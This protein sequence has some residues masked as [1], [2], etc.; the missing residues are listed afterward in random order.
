MFTQDKRLIEV[1][2]PLGA[3]ALV[4]HGLSGSEFISGLFRFS[5]DLL[6]EESARIDPQALLGQSVSVSMLDDNRKRYF[7]GIVSKVAT[8]RRDEHFIHYY[9]EVVPWFWRLSL[10]TTSRIFQD[11]TVVQIIESIFEELKKSFPEVNYRDATTE[12]HIA[13][14]Y[15]VQYRETDLSFVSRLME[16]EGIF[17]FFEHS[18]NKHTLIF[19]DSS[20]A[21]TSC[22]GKSQILYREGGTGEGEGIIT[23]W[24]E[25]WAELSGKYSMRDHH[26]Q[27]P[28]KSL[29]VNDQAHDTQMSSLE[30][31]DYPGE[32]VARF[33]KP[34]QRLA[35]VEKEGQKRIRIHM[36]QELLDE[37]LSAGRSSRR[38]L[39]AGYKFT[40]AKHFAC[41]GD[42]ILTEV[43]HSVAQS[44]DYIS[45]EVANTPYQNRFTCVP[46]KTHLR[47]R[48]VSHK[49]VVSGPQTAVVAVKSGEESWLDKFGRVRVQFFWEREGKDNETSACWVRVAQKWAGTGWGA[50]FWP[51]LGQEV[52]VEFLEGD[53]DRPLITG[54]VY[55]PENMPP[56]ALP[57]NYTRSG[58]VTETSKYNS[59]TNF[60]E[61]RFED[62]EDHEQ[63]FINAERDMDWRVEHDQRESTGNNR[64]LVVKTN[65]T[66]LIEAAKQEHI[67]GQHAEKV[68]GNASR[69]IGGADKKQIAG[70]LSLHVSGAAHQNVGTVYTLVGDEIHLKSSQKIVIDALRVSAKGPGG[71]VDVG[72]AGVAIQGIKVN[73][74][75]GG[76]AGSGTSASP[77]GPDAPKDAVM[78]EDVTARVKA[79]S[80]LAVT[81]RPA[82]A[83]STASATAAAV[84]PPPPAIDTGGTD[85]TFGLSM[86]TAKG[87]C[88]SFV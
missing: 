82:P 28:S 50:H 59:S 54:S 85:S 63:I 52:V 46:A 35:L 41:D 7:H 30:S 1:K 47:P 16:R 24:Q 84:A 73:I 43:Q 55:N 68:D 61:L 86:S 80:K 72:M 11:K 69:E 31:Y 87:T 25:D 10:K 26:F 79:A 6:A 67:K 36:E 40:L 9:A 60:N 39:I 19:A 23:H 34:E 70:K 53:P 42:Y 17:Y 14:D 58:I 51:R 62:K 66:E 48:K 21:I 74:N 22:P 37:V 8:G 18:E 57:D 65:Q 29:E 76:S 33:N 4:I 2:T 20:T 32:F 56:Y 49:P 3:D 71:F 77:D 88:S 27:L 12:D 75:S 83:G 38:N 44:P 15:C 81:A 45:G 5:L 78:A 64:D 13:L